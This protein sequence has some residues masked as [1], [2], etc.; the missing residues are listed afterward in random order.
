VGC[1]KE[2]WVRLVTDNGSRV[3]R[4]FYHPRGC[5]RARQDHLDIDGASATWLWELARPR[6]L[7]LTCIARGG[8]VVVEEPLLGL[9]AVIHPVGDEAL[10]CRDKVYVMVTRS[11]LLYIGPV[12]LVGKRG[13]L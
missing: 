3:L 5:M 9:R 6:G 2:L 11:G 4:A 10:F 13:E 12:G 8:G 7:V 1:K